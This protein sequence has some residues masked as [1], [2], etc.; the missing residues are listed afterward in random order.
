[1][2]LKASIDESDLGN[3][4]KGQ[5]VTFRVDAYPNDVFRGRVAAGAAQP[6]HRVERRHL[7]GDRLGAERAAEAEARHDGDAECRRRRG[8][9]TCCGCRSRRCD[10]SRHRRCL[11]ALADTDVDAGAPGAK[12]KPVATSRARHDA[13]DQGDGLGLRR[14]QHQPGAGHRRHRPTRRS[15]RLSPAIFRKARA[16]ATRVTMPGATTTAP[17]ERAV[18]QSADGAAAA[19]LLT[20]AGSC[21]QSASNSSRHLLLPPVLR[22]ATGGLL[23]IRGGHF[24]VRAVPTRHAERR[25]SRLAGSADE[26][27]YGE[28]PQRDV[29]SSCATGFMSPCGGYA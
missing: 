27:G 24:F 18:E 21:N 17:P 8:R 16:L 22:L 15:P 25:D 19:S 26:N 14:R 11:A 2:Q 1:M 12:A 5:A 9:T 29:R 3:I 23:P 28:S 20:R 7:R 10:S 6:G 13:P 4:K